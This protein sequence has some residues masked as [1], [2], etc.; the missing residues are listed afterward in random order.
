MLAVLIFA[1]HCEEE[2]KAEEKVDADT[3]AESSEPAEKKQDKR[4]LSH[5]FGQGGHGWDHKYEEEKTLTI[6][7]KIPA[8]YPVIKHVP[9]EHVKHIPVPYKVPYPKPYPVEKVR[10]IKIN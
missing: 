6:V 3:N 9:V 7:K 8:P 2:K 1:V 4:G 5:D 10:I